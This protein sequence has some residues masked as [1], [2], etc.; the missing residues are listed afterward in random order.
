MRH[1]HARVADRAGQDD[2]RRQV[3]PRARAARGRPSRSAGGSWP[4]RQS[5]PVWSNWCPV[6]WIG[7][8]SWC[9]ER[10]KRQPV[11][12]PRQA[13]QVLA[14]PDARDRRRDR[15]ERPAD[16]RRRVGLGVPGLELARPAHQHQQDHRP[17]MIGRRSQR[18]CQIEAR[19]RQAE[20]PQAPH[21]EKIAS[22]T[23]Q[24]P[25]RAW[26]VPLTQCIAQTQIVSQGLHSRPPS[27]NRASP[28]RPRRPADRAHSPQFRTPS[29]VL[30][31][32][33]QRS[34]SYHCNGYD[35]A[36]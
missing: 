33:F 2:E 11:H 32:V 9:S 18:P 12:P 1:A 29:P 34:G 16:L 6:S 3:A 7:A 26:F 15:A 8:A 21:A 25:T 14:D 28:Y 17:L 27:G 5:R 24:H 31:P 19:Q 13:G 4:A 20:R 10:I 22:Q 36:G 35:E 23:P 30:G